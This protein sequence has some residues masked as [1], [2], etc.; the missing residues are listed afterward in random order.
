MIPHSSALPSVPPLPD[1][2][3]VLPPLL[4]FFSPLGGPMYAL[5]S[6]FPDVCDPCHLCRHG[7]AWATAPAVSSLPTISRKPAL[8]SVSLPLVRGSWSLHGGPRAGHLRCLASLPSL[9]LRGLSTRPLALPSLF[10]VGGSLPPG[11]SGSPAASPPSRSALSAGLDRYRAPTS[12]GCPAV[13]LA[14]RSL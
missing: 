7:L 11:N 14:R 1:S 3:A 9:R 12:T 13:T 5:L 6:V 2:V 8:L 10:G 4:V